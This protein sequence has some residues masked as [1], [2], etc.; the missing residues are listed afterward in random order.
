MSLFVYE[1]RKRNKVYDF[2]KYFLVTNNKFKK[3]LR[4]YLFMS[5]GK[6]NF[7]T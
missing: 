3:R 1:F 5:L 7:N 2:R 6:N 4:F